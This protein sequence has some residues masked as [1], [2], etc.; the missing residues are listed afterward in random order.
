MLGLRKTLYGKYLAQCLAY[1]KHSI[2]V[3]EGRRPG[4][5][6][7][8][9]PFP[10]EL[11]GHPVDGTCLLVTIDSYHSELILSFLYVS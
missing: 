10:F 4:L 3:R 5:V 1:S 2:N 7:L 9:R 11:K 6:L 8:S